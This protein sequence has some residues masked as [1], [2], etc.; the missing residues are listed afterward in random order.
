M[1]LYFT[2]SRST[3]ER[4]TFLSRKF[5]PDIKCRTVKVDYL[6]LSIAGQITIETYLHSITRFH[7]LVFCK[8]HG[9]FFLE[10]IRTPT[11]HEYIKTIG[12]K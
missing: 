5:V 8:G 6:T 4:A 7:E 1:F 9:I 11:N 3:P 10:N 12:I 2:V